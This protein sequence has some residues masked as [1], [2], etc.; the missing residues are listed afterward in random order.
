MHQAFRKVKRNR[1]A[2]GID[3]QSIAMFAANLEANL[4]ALM[5]QLK[6]GT[7]T[8][9]PLRRKEINQGGGKIRPLGIPAVRDRVAQE[10]LRRLI[11]PYF[12]PAFSEYSYGFRPNRN[13]HQALREVIRLRK[14][15]FCKVLD[16]DIDPESVRDR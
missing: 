5:K 7:Y 4:L 3:K 8:P 1:G 10:V 6:A 12:E 11:E 16:A 14:L 9:R 15:G 13:C 2:A